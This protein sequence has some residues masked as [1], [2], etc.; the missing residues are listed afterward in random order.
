MVRFN[1]VASKYLNHYLAWFRYL[2]MKS[3]E[4]T[5]SDLKEMLIRAYLYSMNKTNKT[6]RDMQFNNAMLAACN[7]QVVLNSFYSLCLNTFCFKYFR[8]VLDSIALSI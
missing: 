2:D 5:T 4:K 1:G 3:Y 8:S 7:R 6:L